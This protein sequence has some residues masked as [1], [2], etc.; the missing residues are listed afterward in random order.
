MPTE[1]VII[2]P[3]S[4]A[5]SLAL[6]TQATNGTTCDEIKKALHLSSNKTVI[7]NQFHE[8]YAVI[9]KDNYTVTTANHVRKECEINEQFQQVARTK[10]MSGVKHLN[11][12]QRND[13]AQMIN[14]FIEK[15]T[16]K[17]VRNLIT[18]SMLNEATKIILVNTIHFNNNWLFPF[19]KEYTYRGD[20]FISENE[21]VEVEYMCVRSARIFYHRRNNIYYI[22]D[23]EAMAVEIYFGTTQF[24]FVIIL[25][26]NRTGLTDL[27]VKLKD[28]DLKNIMENL[29]YALPYTFMPKFEIEFDIE[30]NAILRNG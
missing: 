19:E 16:N 7:A 29:H 10:L 1:N 2:S 15:R 23:L 12:R 20:F 8:L 6:L 27:E 17:T 13:S 5:N 28:Y 4:V 18:P 9:Q 26:D 14:Q 11:F 30:L 21:I 22:H 24:T 3:L 25:P